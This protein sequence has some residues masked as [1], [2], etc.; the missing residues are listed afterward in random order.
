MSLNSINTNV[1]AQ[2]ALQTLNSTNAALENAQNQVSTGLRVAGA[3]DDGAIWSIAQGQRSQITSLGAVTDSLN[4]AS[5]V[6][7]V[8]V[9][10]GQTISDLLNQLK[11]KALEGSDTSLSTSDRAAL[12]DSFKS[13]VSQ[14]NSAVSNASFDGGNLISSGAPNLVAL[15]GPSGSQKLTIAAQSLALG[16]ANVTISASASFSTASHA[17][18]LL[19]II[20]TSITNTNAAVAALGTEAN[21]VTSTLTFV[22]NLTDSLTSGVGNL[23][24]ADV[25]A[26]SATLQALQTKQQLGIQA[27]SIANSS[28]SNLL[29][30]FKG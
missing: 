21:Q 30:L 25:A 5:S 27:L 24:D 12:N 28:S 8:A 13:L 16:G 7:D 20:N 3:E 22:S 10:T 14:I 11:A 18:S 29:S 1:G 23:V 17:A 19:T 9:T 6:L 4:R 26:Q 2:I 15:S